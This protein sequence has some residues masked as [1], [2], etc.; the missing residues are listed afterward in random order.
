MKK[1]HSDKWHMEKWDKDMTNSLVSDL[2][3]DEF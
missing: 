2:Q 3:K 1:W